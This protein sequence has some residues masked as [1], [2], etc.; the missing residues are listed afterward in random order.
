MSSLVSGSSAGD[1]A[2]VPS[3]LGTDLTG[4]SDAWLT[5]LF[6]GGAGSVGSDLGTGFS[7]FGADLSTLFS[8]FSSLF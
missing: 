3:S 8:D 1:P 7:S 5:D 2:T 6:G 4:S